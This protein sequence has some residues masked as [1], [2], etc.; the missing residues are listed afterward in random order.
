MTQ[1]E[2]NLRE[3]TT[4][5]SQK[6]GPWTM[7]Q[8]AGAVRP[9]KRDGPPLPYCSLTKRLQF[10]FVLEYFFCT[11]FKKLGETAGVYGA[12]IFPVRNCS[13]VEKSQ[14]RCFFR[15]AEGLVFEFAVLP[16]TTAEFDRS[17]SMF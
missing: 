14:P 10:L 9:T 3:P 2:Q 6:N 11:R 13:A 17:R 15:R 12:R 7:S 16:Q 4:M 1:T 8:S 5:G